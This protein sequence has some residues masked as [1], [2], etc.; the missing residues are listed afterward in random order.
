MANQLIIKS[1]ASQATNVLL[2][3]L[4]YEIPSSGG[5]VDLTEWE[6]IEQAR[7]SEDLRAFLVDDAFGANSST[8][9][10]NDG[11]GDIAQADAIAFLESVAEPGLNSTYGYIKRADDGTIDSANTFDGQQTFNNLLLGADADAG[12]FKLTN[13]ADGTAATDA[14]TKQQLDSVS[15]GLDPKESVRTSTTAA[16]ST[17]IAAGS[18]VGKTLTSPN[19]LVTNNDFDGV[20]VAVNDRVLVK[21][22]GPN[23]TPAIDNGIYEVT[24]LADGVSNPTILTRATDFDQDVEVTAGAF[25]FITEGSTN[26]DTGWVLQGPD[27]LTV[28][29]S[30][31]NWV[32]FTGAGA[33]VAGDGLTKSG[34]ILNVGAGNGIIVNADDVEVDFGEV[35]DIQPLG[36]ALSAGVLN[37]SA[38]ADHVHTHG[39]RGGD[40]TVSQHDADQVDVET[41]HSEFTNAPGNLEVVLGDINANFR[42]AKYVGKL[43][44]FGHKGRV[45]TGGIQYLAGSGQVL[46]SDVGMRM[47]RAGTLKAGWLQVSDIDATRAFKLS[48]KING[49]EVESVS[50]PVSTLGATSL[51]FTTTFAANDILTISVER[52]SGTGASTFNRI[53]AGVEFVDVT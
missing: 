41:S 19:N 39:D 3:D 43:Y 11:S 9:I 28:D 23:A 26:A 10:L 48:V 50:L 47:L 14:V 52:T 22:G 40:G 34:N 36:I 30:P 15:A 27:P 32:Q 5:Q 4:G 12:G 16:L 2:R 31:L 42:D 18:G 51:A 13:L 37:E 38:R 33:V 17:W 8:L 29:T 1:N 24:Q 44:Q 21:D 7:D 45:P 25:T 20:T 35:G 53:A 46:T 49:S 6:A